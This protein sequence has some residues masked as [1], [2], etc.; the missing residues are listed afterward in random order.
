MKTSRTLN[1]KIN[2]TAARISREY[3][4]VLANGS[5]PSKLSAIINASKYDIMSAI[6]DGR[7]NMNDT[8]EKVRSQA[9]YNIKCELQMRPELAKRLVD[10]RAARQARDEQ[11]AMNEQRKWIPLPAMA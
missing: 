8:L 9:H 7:A 3:I 11:E 1:Q 4:E 10:F 5:E 6:N 2:S